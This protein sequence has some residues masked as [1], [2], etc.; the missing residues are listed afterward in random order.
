MRNVSQFKRKVI[1][2]VQSIPQGKVVNYGQVATYIGVPR[3]ARQVGWILRSM[4]EHVSLPWWRVI[5]NAGKISIKGNKYNTPELQKR[6][7]EQ[8][9]VRVSET[10]RID[11]AKYRFKANNELLRKWGLPGEYREKVLVKYGL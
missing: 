8:D 6:L 10:F 4:D 11:I 9:G 7:L 5:N 2:V 1:L 3:A